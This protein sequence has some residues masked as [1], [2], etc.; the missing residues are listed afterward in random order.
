[1]PG[2]SKVLLI[3][4]EPSISG[5][6]KRGLEDI[7]CEVM[8]AFDGELGLKL[9]KKNSHDIIIL[10][11]VLPGLNGLRVCEII[12]KE[13]DIKTPILMLT[14]LDDTDDV[15]TGLDAGADDYL[16]KPFQFKEL[17][18][19]MRALL[20]RPGNDVVTKRVLEVEDLVMDLDKTSVQRSGV[21]IKLTPKEFFLLKYMVL[22]KNKVLSRSQIL[23]K[24]WEIQFDL[25]TNVVDVYMNYL[26]KKIDK[27]FNK[28]LIQTVVGMGYMIKVVE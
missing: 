2:P 14:A 21:E 27:P 9:A 16:A 3:E 22:N 10:D 5:F 13:L 4:D 28:P 18:A 25:G 20:R 6:I 11:V 23:E 12:R 17:L 26:R 15:V 24:V 7:G 1:M 19:R 8:Q